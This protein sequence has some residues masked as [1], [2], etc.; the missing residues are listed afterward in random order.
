MAKSRTCGRAAA[1]AVLGMALA[2]AQAAPAAAEGTAPFY[3]ERDIALGDTVRASL[4]GGEDEV[5]LLWFYAPLGSVVNLSVAPA[6]DSDVT[7]GLRLVR[8]GGDAVD[9]G[10]AISRSGRTTTVSKF[11][12]PFSGNFAVEVWA[13]KG[14]GGYVLRTSGTLAAQVKGIATRAPAGRNEFRFQAVGGATMKLTLAPRGT[15][16]ARPEIVSVVGPDGVPLEVTPA[17]SGTSSY[18]KGV[19]LPISGTYRVVYE[20]SGGQGDVVVT[21]SFSYPKPG[22]VTRDLGTSLGLPKSVVDTKNTGIAGGV[23]ADGFVGSAACGRCHDELFRGWADTVHNL[24]VRDWRRPGLTGK[25]FVNDVDANG[26]DDFR[27]GLD[28]ATQP[29]FAAYGA[30]APKLSYEAGATYPYKMTIG[31]WK[32]DVART[33]GGNGQWKQRYLLLVNEHLYPSP[34]QFNDGDLVPKAYVTYDAGDWYTGTTP[35]YNY[36]A[37]VPYEKS[38]ENRCSGCHNT[39]ETITRNAGGGYVVGYADFNIGCEQCHGPGAAH[40]EDP[41]VEKPVNPRRFLNGTPEGV[42]KANDVCGKCHTRGAAKDYFPGIE[43]AKAGYPYSQASGVPHVG[44]DGVDLETT[45]DVT[46]SSGDFWGRKTDPYDSTQA[47]WVA[48][49]SHRQQ[50]LDLEMGGHA[51]TVSY[52]PTCFDCHDPHFRRQKHQIVSQ[53]TEVGAAEKA[54][55]DLLAPVTMPTRTDDNSVCLSCHQGH[56]PFLRVTKADVAAISSGTPPQSVVD[57]V[58][59]HMKDIGMP[60]PE[61][62]YDPAGSKVG[63]CVS[64]HMPM[65][66]RTAVSRTDPAG[67]RLNDEH[68]HIFTAV[69]P[70]VSQLYKDGTVGMSNSC[71]VCHGTGDA[72]YTIISQW[73]ADD[74]DADGTFHSDTPRSFQNGVANP[75]RDGGVY[76]VQCHTTAGFVEVQVKGGRMDG[77]R[78][79]KLVRSAIAQDKGIACDA[80]H[81]AQGNGR[82]ATGANPLR[83]EKKDLCGKCHNAQTVVFADFQQ[84]GEMVRHPM[85]EVYASTAGAEV[86]GQTY[87]TGNPHR[88]SSFPDACVSC[89]YNKSSSGATHQFEPQVARCQTC[90]G[91][92]SFDRPGRAGEDWDGDGTVEGSQT[93]VSGLLDKVKAALLAE[94]GVTFANGYFDYNGAT[95]HKLTGAP[96]DVKRGAYNWYSVSFDASRGVH[97][98]TRTIQLLQKSYRELTGTDASTD[99]K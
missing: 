28:L 36:P 19:A 26:Q 58:V 50:A 88:S 22:K 92:T 73:W 71:T 81:G 31:P 64:C 99:L 94:P 18:V 41:W 34:V 5:H 48:S 38:F 86:P 24:A 10:G 6:S 98:P 55:E 1:A 39:G 65:L 8:P 15:S 47:L 87:G 83:F 51:P 32:Y 30:N 82:F 60:V 66:E 90:H 80:C 95:D 9:L 59:E 14:T 62:S 69:N 44:P 77:A 78:A 52:V 89:H 21:P 72:V 79:T 16:K 7:P 3:G 96:D 67:L 53:R 40:V 49:K 20:N 29:A 93:E 45:F 23:A 46:T 85:Q 68:N 56:G 70:R 61:E 33:M 97:N 54:R 25:A 13:R 91:I 35:K 75:N 4:R 63:Q 12:L 74:A 37:Q 42:R 2:V 27:D 11:R 84:Y 43:S 17:R 57:A 76:C